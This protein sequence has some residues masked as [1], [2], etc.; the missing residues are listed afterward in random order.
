M[1]S[2]EEDKVV[3]MFREVGGERGAMFIESQATNPAVHA[4]CIKIAK[5]C[6]WVIQAVLREEERGLAVNEFYRVCREEIQ[7]PLGCEPEV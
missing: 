2:I 1:A 7:K 3:T 4:L 5:R 6:V